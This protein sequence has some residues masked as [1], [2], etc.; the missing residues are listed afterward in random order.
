MLGAILG[1]AGTAA[2]GLMSY[3]NNKKAERAANAEAARQEAYYQG[4]AAENPLARSENQHLLGQYD[5][6]SQQ[7]IEN[8]RG[9][10]AITGA[11]PEFSLGV[12]KGVAHGRADLMGHMASDASRRSDFYNERAEQAR[13]NKAVQEQERI[14]AR[15]ET[16]ANL[17]ANAANV[18]GNSFD[19]YFRGKAV[20]STNETGLNNNPTAP[21]T[22]AGEESLYKYL[23]DT[24]RRTGMPAVRYDP[25]G[26]IG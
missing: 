16:F 8:A 2:S 18:V 22:I 3:F 12:Q 23:E 4:K 15:N 21:E 19:S 13:H 1:L 14:A 25:N 17:A 9:V 5:R 6:A 11:T 10:A 7:Q 20:N 24:K 26:G